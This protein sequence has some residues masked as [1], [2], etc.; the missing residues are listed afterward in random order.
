MRLRPRAPAA[1]A[2]GGRHGGAAEIPP[3]DLPGMHI[4][5]DILAEVFQVEEAGAQAGRA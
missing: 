4:L 1:R 2:I 5:N 3:V